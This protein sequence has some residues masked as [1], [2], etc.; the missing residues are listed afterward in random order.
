MRLAIKL[1]LAGILVGSCGG[2]DNDTPTPPKEKEL[3]SFNLIFPDNNLICT[4]G[5]DNGTD[6]V[7]I[8]F[9]WSASTNATSYELEITNQET[10]STD[11]R[12]VNTTSAAIDLPKGTLFSWTVT[13]VLGEKTLESNSWNFY[14]EGT[15]TENFAPFPAE[16]TVSDNNDGTV[17]I[18]WVGEDLDDDLANYDVYIGITGNMELIL[19]ST[20]DL[21]TIYSIISGQQY[22]IEIVSYDSKGNTSSS[23][24]H[25]IFYES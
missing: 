2:K 20:T 19:E 13:A 18:S 4:E 24:T 9:Q 17:T 15:S 6:G 8:E 5:E 14:S 1:I 16:I 10:N 25:F 22:M 21:S 7:N 23:R 3:G 11:N 12:T